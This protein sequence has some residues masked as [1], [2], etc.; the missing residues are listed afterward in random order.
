VELEQL[1]SRIDLHDLA[2][3]LGL[4]R[5]GGSSGNYRSPHRKDAKPSISI[6]QGGKR[7][8]DHTTGEGGTCIDLM[9]HVRDLEA[10]EAIKQ[11]HEL[12]GFPLDR[13]ERD[14]GFA[15]RKRTRA[16]FIADNCLRNPDLA[17]PY[18]T[19]ERGISE[20]TVRRAI[21]ANA[22]GFNTWN[23]SMRDPKPGQ[24]AV[25]PG[26]VGYGGPAVAFIVHGLASGIIEAVEL[27]YLDPDL[28]GGVKT[29]TQGVKENAPW[30]SSKAALMKA[31]TVV[32]VEAPINALSVDDCQMRK[33]VGVAVRGVAVVESIDWRF[34]V[35]KR[36]IIAMDNDAPNEKGVRPGLHAAWKIYDQ[37]TALGIASH[38]VDQTRWAD[39]EWNDVN[40]ILKDAG[41]EELRKALLQLDP[42][43]IPGQPAGDPGLFAKADADTRSR[44]RVWL[45]AHDSQIYWRFRAKEDF[46]SHIKEWK[47]DDDGQEKIEFEDVCGFRVAGISR[48]Q[49]PSATSTMTG[50]PDTQPRTLF[51]VSV[52]TPEMGNTLVRSVFEHSKLYN[53]DQWGKLGAIFNRTRF[54]RM[55]NILVRGA[56]HG[57]RKA[58]NFVGL[59]WRDGRTVVNEG[60][61]CYFQ[62]PDK[63][64]PYHNLTFPSGSQQ[65]AQTV[66]T[67][68]HRTFMHNAALQLL[69]WALGGHLKA[70][71]GFWPHL[72]LQADKGSGKSVLTGRLSRTIAMTMFS[73]QNLMT[74]FRLLM[75]TSGTSHPVGWEELSARRQDVI[76]KAVSLLQEA[77]SYSVTRRGSDVTEYLISAP[78]LMAGEDVPVRSLTGKVVAVQLGKKGPM[79]PDDLPRFPVREWLQYLAGLSRSTVREA[80]DTALRYCQENAR[81]TGRDEGAKRMVHNYA[82]AL[83]S[84]YLLTDF[85]GLDASQFDFPADLMRQMNAHIAETSEDREPWIWILEKLMSEIAAGEFRHPH[86]FDNVNGRL[87][88]CVR[89]SHVMDH[90][91]HSPRLRDFWH[92]LTIKSDRVF[93][94]Q[95]K[96]AQV[97]VTN[98]EGP[99][100]VEKTIF[101]KRYSGMTPLDVE[102]LEALGMSVPVDQS[103]IMFPSPAIKMPA[104]QSA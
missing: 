10:A 58:I 93:K 71:L 1:K 76:D 97:V 100:E 35:G 88:L 55:V 5:P 29:Q 17:I 9:M 4:E 102:K 103:A 50:D 12:Y 47:Q 45:P 59:A 34:L 44:S 65:D 49:I 7:W 73:G 85:A 22:I 63:Q 8:K 32:L 84:W 72:V 56:D 41:P 80:Y 53:A 30:F 98:D 16:E 36:V 99:M 19:Q 82:A 90:I 79:M 33:T 101:G 94:R 28:N 75:S 3:K 68:Y 77:Y 66:M 91:S 43:I 78:V 18:L 95:L 27:R 70:F 39:H 57:A 46:T 42:G 26:D 31:E 89:T 37:L 104:R 54:M 40:D 38:I 64:C 2:E 48:V 86:I 13:P 69:V 62:E 87:A 92:G 15:P 51:S 60:P 6:F 24:A 61:D 23:A 14:T 96:S 67:W 25:N 11:L 52:Q 81:S 83:T 20:E 74:E 21:K